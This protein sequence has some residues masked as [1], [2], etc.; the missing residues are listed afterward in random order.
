MECL[1]QLESLLWR[2]NQGDLSALADAEILANEISENF[3][4]LAY[5]CV[6][7]LALLNNDIPKAQIAI[8]TAYESFSP[9]SESIDLSMLTALK[10]TPYL[11]LGQLSKCMSLL[12]Q[13]T[14]DN[15]DIQVLIA[16]CQYWSGDF[17][18]AL[19]TYNKAY[20]FAM[21]NES[22]SD[23]AQNCQI[24][25]A[26]CLMRLGKVEQATAILQPMVE[27]IKDTQEQEWDETI[28][29]TLT[30]Y[31]RCLA[32][33]EQVEEAYN[34][35]KMGL[36][37]LKMKHLYHKFYA[38]FGR[39]MVNFIAQ[40]WERA[41]EDFMTIS[42]MPNIR[43]WEKLET[44]VCLAYLENQL[45]HKDKAEMWKQEIQN[46]P[47]TFFAQ[48][49][50]IASLITAPS[51]SQEQAVPAPATQPTPAKVAPQPPPSANS[52]KP[53]HW[54]TLQ[55]ASEPP[56]SVPITNKPAIVVG[57]ESLLKMVP[58]IAIMD[59]MDLLEFES[60]CK[61]K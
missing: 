22:L 33:Q 17:T 31:A 50:T 9:Q 58:L 15:I 42:R 56:P 46:F 30:E 11:Y 10:A 51:P 13:S 8:E 19:V 38:I 7:Q 28:I 61:K 55:L 32:M 34:I 36:S 14:S 53:I 27:A 45:G 29:L 60:Y 23:V 54:A 25:Q 18:N 21:N 4:S 59:G 57:Q 48:I 47:E 24:C 37:P 16:D 39:A 2:C 43:K 1:S 26:R 3:K 20:A 40:E 12:Q 41:R 49:D 5:A 52:L 35:F 44:F 6:A